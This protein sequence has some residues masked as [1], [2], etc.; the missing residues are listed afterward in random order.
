M[1]EKTK[2][3]R[4]RMALTLTPELAAAFRDLTDATGVAASS[5]VVELLTESLPQIRLLTQ[6]ARQAKQSPSQ[7]LESLSEAIVEAQARTSQMGLEI[8]TQ[9][10]R[11]RAS[12]TPGKRKVKHD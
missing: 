5:F 10:K 6:V 2:D 3:T 4:T 11:L 7:A 12:V 9:R 8:Q 1:A